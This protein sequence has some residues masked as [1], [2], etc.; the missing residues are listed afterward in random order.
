[1][2]KIY[3]LFLALIISGSLMAQTPQ[4][5]KYQAV[6]R[7]ASGDVVAG[8]AVGMQISILQSSESGTTIYTETHVD[9]TNQFG[10]VTLEIGTGTTTDDFT[11]I[12]WSNDIY[13]IQIEMDA[14]GGTSYVLI[15][16]S[17]LLS[18]PYALHA[19]TAANIFSGSYNDLSNKP[20]NATTTTD[21]FMSSADKTKL[22]DLQ[23]A[24]GS[25]TKITAGANVTV[26][27][28]GTTASPYVVNAVISMT[29]LQRNALTPT[30]GIIVY[31]S[32]TNKPNYYNGT[33]WMNYDGTSAKTVADGVSHQG[34]IIS[35]IF[36]SGDPGYIAGET[37]GLIAATADQSTSKQWTTST[38]HS[39]TVPSSATSLTDGLANS[40][41]IV[42]QAGVG[43]TYAAG[44]CRA[45]SASGDG[46]LNDWYLP[47]K[48]ELNKLYLNKAAVGGFA[49][50]YYWSSTE[51]NGGNAWLQ[52]FNNGD[53]NGNYKSSTNRVRAVRAF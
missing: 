51:D 27:G 26:T 11:A 13:F 29:E 22:N 44:L 39:V 31:N 3:T 34:G 32:T 52:D 1:M 46:G 35:Y 45:Y 40:N 21:G 4:S 16:T 19:K 7:N 20:T 28:T 47:S 14:T 37:H 10:L 33:E 50:A 12:D 17:Q 8:Q 15:G 24:D 48:D 42:A 49:S 9:S 43:T 41:A 38:Y 18:V 30:A 6:A 23:N 25:E 36:Q 2:K 53:Q 5:F